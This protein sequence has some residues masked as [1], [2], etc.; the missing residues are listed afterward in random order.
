MR[1]G[2]LDC[3]HIDD[4]ESNY[5]DYYSER[6]IKCLKPRLAGW[7]YSSYR[8]IDGELP[9]SLSECDAWLL[10]G[11]RY[12]AYGDIPWISALSRF[13]EEAINAGHKMV[14]VCFGHQ[15]LAQA[16][17]GRVA[18]SECG[19]QLGVQ[20]YQLLASRPWMS[21]DVET[22]TLPV[23]HQDQVQKLPQE[24]SLLAQG[25]CCP[26]FIYEYRNQILGIQ[27]H[28]EFDP[29]YLE[30]L[31]DKLSDKLTPEQRERGLA[32]LANPRLDCE[33]VLDWIANFLR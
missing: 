32:S 30:I 19:W 1:L 25:E 6:F 21:G 27:G 5:G 16:L 11:S 23:A 29:A 28:P 15:L 14:G 17:G 2:I 13:V 24:A 3:D 18:P 26:H 33:R 20:H 12:D 31:L 22:L 10:T 4:R 7:T 8:A 9:S